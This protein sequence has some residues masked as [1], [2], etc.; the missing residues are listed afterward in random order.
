[1]KQC[2][3]RIGAA[4]GA[5]VG[6]SWDMGWIC[7]CY[8][9]IHYTD[10][11]TDITWISTVST[12]YFSGGTRGEDCFARFSYNELKII[13][14]KQAQWTGDRETCKNILEHK[15]KCLTPWTSVLQVAASFL[16]TV[17]SASCSCLILAYQFFSLQNK[18]GRLKH[19]AVKDGFLRPAVPNVA[20]WTGRQKS[21]Y[22]N[23]PL[24]F[25]SAP[26]FGFYFSNSCVLVSG[27]GFLLHNIIFWTLWRTS[28]WSSQELLTPKT[29]ALESY[30]PIQGWSGPTL[31]A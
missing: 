9:F 21:C 14:N 1:M 4:S 30:T 18:L 5:A 23:I 22:K 2:E 11:Y 26:D 12:L 6:E 16:L 7:I 28:S 8:A 19:M 17:P 20:L 27:S 13:R 25:S 31:S 10:N 3:E 29:E 15:T 24:T